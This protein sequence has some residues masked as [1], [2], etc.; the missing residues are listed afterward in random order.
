M[1]G[2]NQYNNSISLRKKTIKLN[3]IRFTPLRSQL[4]QQFGFENAFLNAFSVKLCVLFMHC[5][6]CLATN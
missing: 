4:A 5:N 6:K 2:S 3:S 1:D